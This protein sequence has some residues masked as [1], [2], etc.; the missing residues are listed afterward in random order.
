MSRPMS[1]EEPPYPPESYAW[2][3]VGVLVVA[4]VFSFIDRQILSLLVQPI[5][6][7]LGVNDTQISLLQGFAFAIFYTFMGIPIGRLVDSGSRRTII[8]VGIVFW[9]LS[10]VACGMVSSYSGLLMARVGVAVGEAALSPAAY[11]LITDYFRKEKVGTAIGVYGSGMYLGSGLA[12]IIGGFVVQAAVGWGAVE[13][14]VVGLIHGWQLVFFAV[15]LPGI[16]VGAL[17]YTIREPIRRGTRMVQGADGASRVEKVPPA[18]VVGYLVRNRR[19]FLSHNFGYALLALIAYGAGAWVPTFFI[20]TFGW[21]PAEI[22]FRFGMSILIFASLG[23]VFGGWFGDYL[24]RRGLP[25]GKL[26][27][28]VLAACIQF[29]MAF[30]YP[31]VNDPMV[32]LALTALPNFLVGMSFG[33][34]PG[35]VQELAPNQMRGQ[36]S[37][38]YLFI[39]NIIGLGLGPTAVA[40][41]TDYVFQDVQMLRWSLMIV[42]VVLL[43][44]AIA[45]MLSGRGAYRRTLEEAAQWAAKRAEAEALAAAKG[46]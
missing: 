4:L 10:T 9:S 34:A 36:A 19:A 2:Y 23:A 8:A 13:I 1:A 5:R 26:L 6:Q 45:V 25:E 12:L 31:L 37:A 41:I 7:D 3:V 24:K 32:M 16:L 40:A 28:G 29:P 42:P 39:A 14:P 35:G 17:V 15:G 27:V 11:S 22:G 30:A 18:E 43:P 46:G 20:R 38:L 44:V 21:T 33:A